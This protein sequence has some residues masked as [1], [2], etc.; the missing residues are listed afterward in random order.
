MNPVFT[1]RKAIMTLLM[2][3]GCIAVFTT[4]ARA[5]PAQPSEIGVLIEQLPHV[6][7]VMVSSRF[8]E[9]GIQPSIGQVWYDGTD[10]IV[11]IDFQSTGGPRGD[12]GWVVWTTLG[13]PEVGQHTLSVRHASLGTL[14]VSQSFETLE[15]GPL[16]EKLGV[17]LS[18]FQMLGSYDFDALGPEIYP[19]VRSVVPGPS[20]FIAQA[21][22]ATPTIGGISI[23]P[24]GVGIQPISPDL[25]AQDCPDYPLRWRFEFKNVGNVD[26]A[27]V[28]MDLSP[29]SA[30][31]LSQTSFIT[32]LVQAGGSVNFETDVKAIGGAPSLKNVTYDLSWSDVNGNSDSLS[33]EL[34]VSIARCSSYAKSGQD[35]STASGS[36][37]LAIRPGNSS[38]SWNFENWDW[39]GS[40]GEFLPTEDQYTFGNLNIPPEE[41]QGNVGVPTV[42]IQSAGGAVIGAVGK[43]TFDL[44]S[45]GETS[46]RGVL[47]GAAA[48]AI[49]ADI[50]PAIKVGKALVK[51]IKAV[52]GFFKKLFSGPETLKFGQTVVF[53]DLF[54]IDGQIDA[55][56]L[57]GTTE[58]YRF[59]GRGDPIPGSPFGSTVTLVSKLAVPHFASCSSGPNL[60]LDDP[61]MDAAARIWA[62][63]ETTGGCGVPKDAALFDSITAWAT[64][65]R[66]TA[67]AAQR[68]PSLDSVDLRGSAFGSE[69]LAASPGGTF[70]VRLRVKADVPVQGLLAAL[71]IPEGWKERPL[72]RAGAF[73]QRRGSK[74]LWLQFSEEGVEVTYK[75]GVADE[76]QP[77]TY[78]LGGRLTTASGESF[79]I[80][81]VEVE[82]AGRRPYVPSR[83]LPGVVAPSSL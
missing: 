42:I 76:A 24:G 16:A 53:E 81:P 31:Q 71:E 13:I 36:Q 77:G 14:L 44:V 17:E 83:K 26:L 49:V 34:P 67:V 82:V 51:G 37:P 61:E 62:R 66:T 20:K 75:I 12:E 43:A 30:L 56:L 79:E 25:L 27:S 41:L 58:S 18:F 63:G 72:D 5:V 40:V 80:A 38:Y 29:P 4:S 78:T 3:L 54:Y 22:A 60:L 35:R 9:E 46:V 15:V 59:I 52:G 6:T 47:A 1:P 73:Y 65:S 7:S 11:D 2:A 64:N 69:A 10:Y 32:S 39:A 28:T 50:G 74:L 68:R 48:G 70:E 33:G 19:S 8:A 23:T 21:K 55:T 57:D 45:E